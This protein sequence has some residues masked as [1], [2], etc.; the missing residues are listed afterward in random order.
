MADGTSAKSKAKSIIFGLFQPA[1]PLE[2]ILDRLRKMDLP[3]REVELSSTFP[4]KALP[5]GVGWRR[6]QL[7][8]VTLIAGAIGILFGF[9][10]A[11]GSMAIYP[12]RTGGKPIVP[13][14]IVGIVS[15]ETM[16][17]F[18]IVTTFLTTAIKIIRS[19]RGKVEYD[20]RIDEGFFGIS[21]WVDRDDPRTGTIQTLF[22]EF[23]AVEVEVR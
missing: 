20:N 9:L 23:G 8:H 17:L 6:V 11:G 14:P 1:T 22:Q 12:L 21:V 18:A 13:M 3:E 16:M 15:Y 2:P 5:V 4:M 10:L 7:Y 19:H